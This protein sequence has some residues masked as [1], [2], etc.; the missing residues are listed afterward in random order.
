MEDC[1]VC[2]SKGIS[3]ITR[4]LSK[5]M[6]ESTGSHKGGARTAAK[7]GETKGC[8]TGAA[9]PFPARGESLC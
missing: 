2:L 9:I 5:R 3:R 6:S 7:G 4:H 8:V 1:S